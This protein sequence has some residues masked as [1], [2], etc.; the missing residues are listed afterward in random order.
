MCV[1]VF[2]LTLLSLSSSSV[3]SIQEAVF[4][5]RLHH[6]AVHRKADLS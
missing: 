3:H 6:V 5:E 2:Y 4:P 1:C